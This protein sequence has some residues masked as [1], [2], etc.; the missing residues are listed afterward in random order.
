MKSIVRATAMLSGSSFIT[1]AVGLVS[2]KTLA[3]L[4][5]PNG[6][7]YYGLIQSVVAVVSLVTGMGIATGMVRQGAGAASS[8]D[9]E[10]VSVLRNGAWALFGVLGGISLLILTLFRGPLSRLGGLNEPIVMPIVGVIVL[11]TVANNIQT[12]ILNTYHRVA[13]LATYAIVNAVVCACI[14]VSVVLV[15]RSR[16]III[17]VLG[18]AIASWTISA[19][20]LRRHVGR[21]VMKF[22]RQET[23]HAAWLLLQFGGTFT[24]STLV[25]TGVQL[26]L[27]IVVFHLLS[28]DSVGYYKAASAIAVGYL[29]FIVTAMGQD[30]FPRVSAARDNPKALIQL[31]NEQHRLVMLL[32]VPV[33]L[34]TLALVPYLI[35]LVYSHK[36][37]PAVEILEW[38]LIGDLF[39]FSSWTMSFAI[40]ARCKSSIY[41]LTESI[42]G[43]TT[44][45][46]TWIGVRLFGL[47]GLGI[48]SLVMF[49]IY[50]AVTWIVIRHEVRLTWTSANKKMMLAA[51]CAATIVRIL[52][53][54]RFSD[55]RTPIAVVLAMGASVLSMRVLWRQY[56][57]GKGSQQPAKVATMS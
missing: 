57:E 42:G 53:S 51:V 13:V 32:A 4:L 23:L 20:M 48:A 25:G 10:A 9:E 17:A 36:F 12:G 35:P 52:P 15:W 24:L 21:P 7:G 31:I 54:T 27:P 44:L 3:I 29:G 28:T 50:Y 56:R 41:F 19:I 37:A 46:T 5:H 38:Q 49:I 1:I 39:K 40:L 33:I 18:G 22:F 14:T 26:A 11:F 55:F 16:G 47:P 30:Y 34:G 2:A 8:K 45:A 43:A 6:Y